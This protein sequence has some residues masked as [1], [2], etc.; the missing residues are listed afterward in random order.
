[1]SLSAASASAPRVLVVDDNRDAAELLYELLGLRNFNPTV[2]YDGVAAL[3]LMRRHDFDLGVFDID[4]P[5]IDGYEL[6]RRVRRKVGDGIG[7][8]ALT[9]YGQ[10][11]DRRR[12][13]AAGFDRH[14]VKPVQPAKLLEVLVE[15]TPD[16]LAD[17]D[18]S[19]DRDEAADD[20]D[21]ATTH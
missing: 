8:V 15:L 16:D 1:M 21:S 14:L 9:G 11:A 7:L 4:M 5:L 2:A 13:L 6:A 17:A 18:D 20:G 19:A 3:D 12:A 10:P